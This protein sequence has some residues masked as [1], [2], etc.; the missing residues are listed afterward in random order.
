MDRATKIS[1]LHAEY[2]RLTGLRV[3]LA[4]RE[5]CWWEWIKRELTLDDLRLLIKNKQRRIRAGECTP[6]SLAFRFLIGNSD[7]AEE[8]VLSLRAAARSP[9]VSAG[10]ADVLRATGRAVTRAGQGDAKL[11]AEKVKADAK[12]KITA[13][14]K[15]AAI[16]G[17]GA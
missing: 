14:A 1:E 3:S 8:D 6:R 15:T 4:G 16:A 12:V 7:V 10:R 13:E 9:R 5:W 11:A 2:Q 17:E